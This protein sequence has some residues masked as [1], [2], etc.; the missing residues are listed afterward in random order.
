MV[1]VQPTDKGKLCFF[2]GD[3]SWEGFGGATQ[4]FDN[5]VTSRIGLR[6][7]KFADGGSN[8]RKAYNKVNPLLE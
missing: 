6:D 7:P 5:R 3:A 1:P 8:L 2:V 4:L